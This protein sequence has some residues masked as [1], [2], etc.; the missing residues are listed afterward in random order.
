MLLF[1]RIE[2][3]RYVPAGMST[4]PPPLAAAASIA[5]LIAGESRAL[6]SPLAPNTRTSNELVKA[7]NG[8]AAGRAFEGATLLRSCVQPETIN[9][10]SNR[11]TVRG[12]A[13]IFITAL[14]IGKA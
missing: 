2:K 7:A 5:L 3:L 8:G 13:L 6:P 14:L 11:L 1:S 9:V 4:V 12:L 10:A